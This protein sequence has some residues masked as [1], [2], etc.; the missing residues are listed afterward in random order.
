MKRAE[1][2]VDTCIFYLL[3]VIDS[4]DNDIVP[5]RLARHCTDPGAALRSLD[6]LMAGRE[7][8]RNSLSPRIVHVR[9]MGSGGCRP[10]RSDPE[11]TRTP[12]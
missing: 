7:I 1:T 3:G 9:E 8:T 10:P 12:D 5:A 11:T 6:E 2:R 4:V